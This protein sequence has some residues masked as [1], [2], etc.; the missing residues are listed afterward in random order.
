MYS[1]FSTSIGSIVG[2]VGGSSE[3]TELSDVIDSVGAEESLVCLDENNQD[4]HMA[5]LLD[6]S[7]GNVMWLPM[8]DPSFVRMK[9]MC[10]SQ[11][12]SMLRDDYRNSVYEAAISRSIDAFR[13]H[14]QRNPVILDIGT[15]TG[16]LALLCARYGA[17]AVFAV[18]MFDLLAETAQ[19]II[20]HNGVS[21]KILIVQGRSSDVE[22]LPVPVDIIVS[23][24]LDSA[25]LGESVI[26]SHADAINRFIDPSTIPAIDGSTEVNGESAKLYPLENRV[27]PHSAEMQATL[28]QSAEVNNMVNVHDLLPSHVASSTTVY[29]ESEHAPYCPGSGQMFPVH[30]KTLV[31]RSQRNPSSPAPAKPLSD[32]VPCLHVEFWHTNPQLTHKDNS[33]Y[34][35]FD[36]EIAIKDSGVL[37]GV[38][39]HWKAHL[40]S[41]NIDPGH[42]VTYSTDPATLSMY[43]FQDHWKQCVYPLT[44][45]FS[46]SKGQVVH[47]RVC[48]DDLHTWAFVS[49]TP[50]PTTASESVAGEGAQVAAANDTF[51][52]HTHTA[53]FCAPDMSSQILDSDKKSHDGSLLGKKRTRTAQFAKRSL[54][55]MVSREFQDAFAVPQCTCGWHLLHDNHALAAFKDRPS[56]AY[57]LQLARDIVQSFVAKFI[58]PVSGVFVTLNPQYV[59]DASG[60]TQP[61]QRPALHVL[62]LNDGSFATLLL[63]KLL[64]R[65]LYPVYT[66]ALN[67][68]HALAQTLYQQPLPRHLWPEILIDSREDKAFSRMFYSHLLGANGVLRCDEVTPTVDAVTAEDMV[69]VRVLD[70]RGEPVPVE[71]EQQVQAAQAQLTENVDGDED[72]TMQTDAQMS[73]DPVVLPTYDAVYSTPMRGKYTLSAL[74]LW[75]ALSYL[76]ATRAIVFQQHQQQQQQAQLTGSSSLPRELSSSWGVPKVSPSGARIMMLPFQSDMLL[77]GHGPVER[78]LKRYF[79]LLIFSL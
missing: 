79:G 21:D 15:G 1:G 52:G 22:A 28:I 65:L 67:A 43:A 59:A 60:A 32:A 6:P 72:E 20:H 64:Q 19:E 40:L 7:S 8:Q 49:A 62:D 9:T 54:S 39:F 10:M 18:E 44:Q 17:E 73:G 61:P 76:Y 58:D 2:R 56:Q 66:A 26:P 31:Q 77:K 13:Q 12:S 41:P 16:L 23:E 35:M 38:L 30:W 63:V 5:S 4:I 53:T 48:H 33:G 24:L 11:M 68:S 69:A 51:S 34:A 3:L 42:S 55:C 50:F 78:Y 37:H 47:L 29:R 46:V 70:Q 75:Q 71:A 45:P 14:H 74:P 27:I 36:T 57:L 25:L